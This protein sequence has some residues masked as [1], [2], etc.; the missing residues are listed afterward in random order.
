MRRT[1]RVETWLSD[2]EYD[3]LRRLASIDDRP[4]SAVLRHAVR[5][6]TGLV[7][8]RR[9]HRRSTGFIMP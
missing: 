3:T 5:H 6:Y 8:R 7:L 9:H 4:M 1:R 2:Q